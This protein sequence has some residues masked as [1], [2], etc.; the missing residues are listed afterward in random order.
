MADE[1]QSRSER[2]AAWVDGVCKTCGAATHSCKCAHPPSPLMDELLGQGAIEA[3]PRP[4]AYLLANVATAADYWIKGGREHPD[5]DTAILALEQAVN[6]YKNAAYDFAEKL[7]FSGYLT[8]HL[9]APRSERLAWQ[10][11]EPR[12]VCAALKDANGRIVTGARHFDEVMMEQIN[13]R[14]H[15]LDW[16]G[17][18]QGF[19]DQK[20]NY[21]TR[22]EAHVIASR[23]GQ[24]L[25]R[26]GSDEC[27]LFSENLY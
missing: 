12:V 7:H 9:D 19:I 21:L 3:K 8:Q 22:E 11:G 15:R 1:P 25:R 13:E 20:G 6:A 24:I 14:P 23:H 26:V 4:G 17:A 10:P 2:Q 18:D 5:R 16:R 27:S